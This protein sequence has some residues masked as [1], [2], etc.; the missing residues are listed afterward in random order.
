MHGGNRR[1]AEPAE[2]QDQRVPPILEHAA[3]IR[4]AA[5][6]LEVLAGAEGAP[7]A[8]KNHSAAGSV[9][10]RIVEGSVQRLL[11]GAIEGVEPLRA[12]EHQ[13]APARMLLDEHGLGHAAFPRV[14]LRV[15]LACGGLLHFTGRPFNY[16]IA[17]AGVNTARR[18]GRL[19][20]SSSRPIA[21]P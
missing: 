14:V 8:R 2:A 19:W 4:L 3:E 20:R 5:H 15:G 9:R 10:L 6:R 16:S 12:I 13:T 11:H 21:S 18:E 1:H 7:R 17:E